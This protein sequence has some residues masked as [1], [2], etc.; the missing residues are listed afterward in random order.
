MIYD[1]GE[2]RLFYSDVSFNYQHGLSIRPDSAPIGFLLSFLN[3]PTY[4][5]RQITYVNGT[6]IRSN[7]F[8]WFMASCN[9]SSCIILYKWFFI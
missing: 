2:R 1:G 5:C 7:G 4:A 9:M 3:S 8:L 6:S